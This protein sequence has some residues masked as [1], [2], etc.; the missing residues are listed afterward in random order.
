MNLEQ[1]HLFGLPPH[2]SSVTQKSTQ[3]HAWRATPTHHLSDTW[4][5]LAAVTWLFWN[6]VT[7][8]REFPT[9][10]HTLFK[11]SRCCPS[12]CR[13]CVCVC[14]CVCVF[15]PS[16]YVNMHKPFP[17]WLLDLVTPHARLSPARN[18]RWP[19]IARPLTPLFLSQ[20]YSWPPSPLQ[21]KLAENSLTVCVCV[22]SCVCLCA[23]FESGCAV[24][25]IL[26]V[27]ANCVQLRI[28]LAPGCDTWCSR[29]TMLHWQDQ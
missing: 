9:W 26:P 27:C 29:L 23:S 4:M 14:V 22:H 17:S 21:G 25:L 6:V 10:L 18:L 2:F 12:P 3:T 7:V 20:T 1:P 24:W 5:W 8:T 19:F 16:I 15:S 28:S 11:G 13:V